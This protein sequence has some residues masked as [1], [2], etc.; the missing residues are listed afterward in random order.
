MKSKMVFMVYLTCVNL[1]WWLHLEYLLNSHEW[2]FVRICA[3]TTLMGIGAATIVATCLTPL[4]PTVFDH[5]L[6]RRV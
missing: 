4:C 3:E 2:L 1:S 6:G 5:S